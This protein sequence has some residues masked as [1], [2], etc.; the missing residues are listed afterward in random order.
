MLLGLSVFQSVI[1]RLKEEDEEA[2]REE[3]GTR[4][5]RMPGLGR[6]FVIETVLNEP[7][8]ATAVAA[9][10]LDFLPDPPRPVPVEEPSPP[11]IPAHLLRLSPEEILEDLAITNADTA[12]TL[13]DKRR[14]FAR[15]NHPDMV[16]P[17]FRDSATT[18]MKTAN[19]LID[20][21]IR[22]S[23]LYR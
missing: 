17:D 12:A 20:E 8:A 1:D 22:I 7:E 11:V 13:A 23:V 19:R 15:A 16:H 4:E 9:A 3:R 5:W 14:D 21:A 6:G 10:Y 2:A 18:R